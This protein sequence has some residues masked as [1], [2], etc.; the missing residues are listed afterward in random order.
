MVLLS[1]Y[2]LLLIPP[3]TCLF[4]LKSK[5]EQLYKILGILHTNYVSLWEMSWKPHAICL[6]HKNLWDKQLSLNI[7]HRLT[8]KNVLSNFC[9]KWHSL[10]IFQFC[11]LDT[12]LINKHFCYQICWTSNN[13]LIVNQLSS[14]LRKNIM[15]SDLCTWF[16]PTDA[17][18]VLITDIS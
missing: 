16:S 17:H 8:I 12:L 15:Y 5:I 3:I 14:I 6:K 1:E 9:F 4:V 10:W 2:I 18:I 7:F 13:D 11:F